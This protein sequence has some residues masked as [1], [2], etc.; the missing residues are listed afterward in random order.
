MS[1][2]NKKYKRKPGQERDEIVGKV[3]Y[4]RQFSSKLLNNKRDILVWLPNGY[5][6]Q[7]QPDKNYPVLYMHDGQNII[8]PKTSF[9]GKDWRIDETITKLIRQ[10]K[11]KEII[12]VGTGESVLIDAANEHEKLLELCRALDVRPS[13]QTRQNSISVM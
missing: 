4:Y 12:V 13:S 2:E 6:P 10:K 3:E 1:E 7:K 9:A 5:N 11:M 8:D